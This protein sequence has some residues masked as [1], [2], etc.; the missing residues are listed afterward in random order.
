M[1]VVIG[2]GHLSM[3]VKLIES[4]RF[5]SRQIQLCLPSGEEVYRHYRAR[6]VQLYRRQVTQSRHWRC[7]PG[8]ALGDSKH[9]QKWADSD[10]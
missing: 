8:L 10:R 7:D 3:F 5:A 6:E 9:A 1:M 4:V 2:I